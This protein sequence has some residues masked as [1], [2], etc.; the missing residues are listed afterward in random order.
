[1]VNYLVDDKDVVHTYFNLS[2]ECKLSRIF[3]IY[4]AV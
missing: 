2:K 3:L 1:M 4:T